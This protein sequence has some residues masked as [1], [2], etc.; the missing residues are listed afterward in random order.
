MQF[1]NPSTRNFKK[2][3]KISNNNRCHICHHALKNTGVLVWNTRIQDADSIKCINCLT[4]YSSSFAIKDL[5]L[6]RD[7]GYS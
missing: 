6:P 1:K 4:V 5:G 3:K 7:V 2:L